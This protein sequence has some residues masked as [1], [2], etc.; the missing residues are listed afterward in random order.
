[1]R[2]RIHARPRSL[3]SPQVFC[4]VS[5]ISELVR[6]LTF[7]NFCQGVDAANVARLRLARFD[8]GGGGGGAGAGAGA[9]AGEGGGDR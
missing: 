2:R 4:M 6:P 7:E 5:V 1:M 3:F 9:G 8:G